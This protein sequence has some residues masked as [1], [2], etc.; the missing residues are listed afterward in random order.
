MS[1]AIPQPLLIILFFTF[2]PPWVPPVIFSLVLI[3][4]STNCP[5]ELFLCRKA[6]IMQFS[7]LCKKS[8]F[9]AQPTPS[10]PPCVHLYTY[11]SCLEPTP[12]TYGYYLWKYLL[13]Q[14][15]LNGNR[16][17][18]KIVKLNEKSIASDSSW[19]SRVNYYNFHFLQTPLQYFPSHP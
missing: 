15:T 10:P 14:D 3:K 7:V 8:N 12:K 19:L 18:L 16:N 6:Y 13:T 4:K 9:T 17:M 1:L 11:V 2:P 5:E